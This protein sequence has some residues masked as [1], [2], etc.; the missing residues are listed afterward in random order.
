MKKPTR[1]E[2]DQIVLTVIKLR[3]AGW[4]TGKI[5][6]WLKKNHGMATRTTADYLARARAEAGGTIADRKAELLEE[7]LAF[8]EEVRAD[9]NNTT[10]DRLAAQDQISEL[11]GIKMPR[12]VF[13]SD[14]TGQQPATFNVT[15]SV[16]L[17][18]DQSQVAALSAALDALDGVAC[19]DEGQ[20]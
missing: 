11:T 4:S 14:A 3:G 2:R 13:L 12:A 19:P 18:L 7:G 9:S 1:Q 8:L 16:M 15:S 20:K 5:R 17:G 6:Q 10:R